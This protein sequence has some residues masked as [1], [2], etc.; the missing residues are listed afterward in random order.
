MSDLRGVV[1][2]EKA[3]MGVLITMG[4]PTK[5]IRSEAAGAGFYVSPAKTRHPKLQ[6][7]TIDDLLAG[8]KIDMPPWHEQRTFK[9]APKRRSGKLRQPTLPFDD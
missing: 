8:K 9:K 2:R 3:A 7:L 4:E 6:V 5:P 1:E